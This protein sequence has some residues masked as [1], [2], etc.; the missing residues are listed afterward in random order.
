MAICYSVEGT[1]ISDIILVISLIMKK[2]KNIGVSL[3]GGTT[4][5]QLEIFS[6]PRDKLKGL[7]FFK[8]SRLPPSSVVHHLTHLKFKLV[9]HVSTKGSR[10]SIRN[11]KPCTCRS[12]YS[13][14]R[15]GLLAKE[16]GL[17]GAGLHRPPY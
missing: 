1:I 14:C 12:R 11:R 4:A 7:S 16:A 8:I 2:R 5:E 3:I 15:G 10:I 6:A 13:A 17:Q 9:H